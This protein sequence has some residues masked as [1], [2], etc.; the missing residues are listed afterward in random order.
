MKPLMKIKDVF[1]DKDNLLQEAKSLEKTCLILGTQ[2]NTVKLVPM[3][4]R[5]PC[6]LKFYKDFEKKYDNNLGEVSVS[7]MYINAEETTTREIENNPKDIQCV[8]NILLLGDKNKVEFKDVGEF[9]YNKAAILNTPHMHR[10]VSSTDIILCCIGFRDLSYEEV[11]CK[12]KS[13][14]NS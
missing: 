4:E 5:T 2:G 10:A 13:K 3:N 7:Y 9:S 14:I 1:W 6:L 8:F 11:I 12:V